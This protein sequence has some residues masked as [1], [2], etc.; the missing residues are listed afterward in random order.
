MPIFNERHYQTASHKPDIA[1]Y[2]TDLRL[3]LSQC[4]TTEAREG[5]LRGEVIEM[6]RHVTDGIRDLIKN[7]RRIRN[8]VLN[9]GAVPLASWTNA[10]DGMAQ[11]P[12]PVLKTQIATM[13]RDLEQGKIQGFPGTM[14]L[15]GKPTFATLEDF[16]AVVFSEAE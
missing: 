5:L 7:D 11:R 12:L 8:L 14:V 6:T 16:F 3:A 15:Y 13:H 2:Q 9:Q 10:L 1:G 4:A